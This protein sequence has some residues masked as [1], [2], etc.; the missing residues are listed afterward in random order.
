MGDRNPLGFLKEFA[1]NLADPKRQEFK[2]NQTLLRQQ[3]LLKN[4]ANLTR[5]SGINAAN[6]EQEKIRAAATGE[7]AFREARA[8]FGK[9]TLDAIE[10]GAPAS[11]IEQFATR[12]GIPADQMQRLP[13]LGPTRIDPNVGA[14]N[15]TPIQQSAIGLEGAKAAQAQ[16]GARTARPRAD[17]IFDLPGA[18]L[19][20]KIRSAGGLPKE[21][22]PPEDESL[23]FLREYREARKAAADRTIITE[24]IIGPIK[25]RVS[26][27]DDP[28]LEAL[29]RDLERRLGLAPTEARTGLT[30]EQE[31]ELD[32]LLF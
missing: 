8:A 14:L 28:G 3:A 12:A 31:A 17:T 5:Q 15:L 9:L 1:L 20:Q 13:G 25:K 27:I 19:E 10:A 6:I 2:R 4:Q 30:P 29:I 22:A 21:F 23:G 32:K 16:A 24:S 7:K 11:F 26:G 18:T